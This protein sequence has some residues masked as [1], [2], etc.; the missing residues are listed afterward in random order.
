MQ[1]YSLLKDGIGGSGGSTLM[2]GA[3]IAIHCLALCMDVPHLQCTSLAVVGMTCHNFCSI[4]IV[5][6]HT[7]SCFPPLQYSTDC[8]IAVFHRL[9]TDARD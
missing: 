6:V 7:M 8:H 1:Y 5:S 9:L 3:S 2:V 4:P